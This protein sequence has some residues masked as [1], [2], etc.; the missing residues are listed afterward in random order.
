MTMTGPKVRDYT[1]QGRT[2]RVEID[3]SPAYELVLSLFAFGCGDRSD[4][5][6]GPDWFEKAY[7]KASPELQKG[8]DLI[9]ATGELAVELLAM[10]HDLP[11]PKSVEALL[12][13]LEEIDPTELRAEMLRSW[14]SGA[15]AADLTALAAGDLE[16]LDRLLADDPHAAKH[17][18]GFEALLGEAPGEFRDKLVDTLRR[19]ADELLTDPAELVPVLERDAREKEALA[20]TLPPERLVE[21]A[22]NGVTFAMQPDVSGVVLIPSVVIRPWVVIAEHGSLR[23]FA[24]PVTDESMAADPDAPPDWIVSFYKALGDERRLRILGI[25]AD[26]PS[27]LGDLTERLELTKSTVHHHV[28]ALRRAGLVRI[29]LGE[30]KEYSL[31][32]DAVPQAGLLLQSFLEQNTK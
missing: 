31:R 10:V 25:L 20:A 14:F 29:T 12:A 7:A 16:L 24:Y 2:L 30:D 15:S 19:F 11:A 17:R 8:L 27:S 18:Q 28:S 21:V 13:H 1:D 3:V 9:V 32:T 6:L 23:L 4:Y 22:T 26:G 5:E